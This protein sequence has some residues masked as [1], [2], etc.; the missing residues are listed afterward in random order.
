MHVRSHEA[1]T[2]VFERPEQ[3]GR[4]PVLVAKLETTRAE[5]H[6]FQFVRGMLRVGLVVLMLAGLFA[7][8][9]W[10]WP[11]GVSVRAAG[12]VGLAVVAASL[13]CR[14]LLA[15]R[16]FGR[17]DAAAAVEARFP[18][19]GQSV[20]TTLEYTEPAPDT[21]PAAPYLIRALAEDTERRTGALPFHSLIPWKS[22]RRLQVGV[23]AV[24]LLYG[25]ALA[26]NAEL[27]TAALRLFLVPVN[28]TQLA[29][30]PKDL[31]MKVG[32]EFTVSATVSG[33]PVARAELLYRQA[34]STD[35]W[36]AR[37]MGNNDAAGKT[38]QLL[39]AFDTTLADCQT[40]LE[41][42][43]VAGP[44]ESPTY[45]LTLLR[46][47][48]LKKFE[49]TLEPPT[50]TR[51]PVTVAKEG[52]FK[53]LEG[54]RVRFRIGLDRAAEE[55]NLLLYLVKDP[56][57]PATDHL[58]P[59]LLRV[60][61]EDLLGELAAVDHELE[62]DIVAR[63]AYGMRLEQPARFRIRVQPDR[64]PTIR[65]VKPTDQI[66][67]TPTTEVAFKVEA[68][69]DYGL[70]K[71]GIVYQVGD[72][73]KKTLY[74]QD[75]PHQ[76][77]A[78]IVEAALALE[79]QEVSFQDGVSYYAFAVDNRPGKPQQTTTELQFID[80]RPFK[81]SYQVLKSEGGT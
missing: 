61:G 73:P 68:A 38:P 15:R 76:P 13:A 4:L 40:D 42:R 47:L 14:Q 72:G 39:G 53:V 75:Y 11:L 36:T 78:L 79:E 58:P 55:A 8:I 16:R 66:E 49:A 19:L 81:R 17:S 64:K 31:S 27:R 33:R 56:A 54:S 34:G 70:T 41:Y 71:V 18:E 48:V 43:V 22:L 6:I 20:R 51:Q 25:L 30:E 37:S 35:D 74:L 69:D 62:Y 2:A 12:L 67:V 57:K 44:V 5:M 24:V 65:F 9:D 45:R 52:N 77:T 32:G 3:R 1:E 23:I 63:A 10:M 21:S 46:P 26:G 28:Y 50:Y 29:V 80:I 59:V 7:F 60:E